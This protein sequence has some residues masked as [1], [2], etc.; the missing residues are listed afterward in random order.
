MSKTFN[1]SACGERGKALRGPG[2]SHSWSSL[3]LPPVSR[4]RYRYHRPYFPAIWGSC[5]LRIFLQSI[6]STKT[7][8]LCR[9]GL[10]NR[11]P[12]H[13]LSS[14]TFRCSEPWP[15]KGESMSVS[16]SRGHDYRLD[17]EQAGRSTQLAVS[18]IHRTTREVSFWRPSTFSQ[19]NSI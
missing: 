1:T 9:Y 13:N 14:L 16:F 4:R 12:E 3:F 7:S 11:Y 15:P 5:N 18:S 17:G 8:C 10:R 6:S 19:K 2:S